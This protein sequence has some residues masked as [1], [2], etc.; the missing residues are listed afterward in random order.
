MKHLKGYK[1]FESIDIIDVEFVKDL[2]F[3]C[4]E[5]MF[6]NQ[7]MEFMGNGN[8]ISEEVLIM[9]DDTKNKPNKIYVKITQCSHRIG[10]ENEPVIEVLLYTSIDNR[11]SR[12]NPNPFSFY[13]GVSDEM[14]SKKRRLAFLKPLNDRLKPHQLLLMEIR[15]MNLYYRVKGYP[16]NIYNSKMREQRIII[17]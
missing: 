7:T 15:N 17:R 1:I 14:E 8:L 16:E 9:D 13:N 10:A 12:S 2:F 11:F 3:S 4:Y 6:D 5:D